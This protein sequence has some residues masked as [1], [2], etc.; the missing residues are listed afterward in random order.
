MNY[1]RRRIIEVKVKDGRTAP[2]L[3]GEIDFYTFWNYLYS[4][5]FVSFGCLL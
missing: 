1:C 3:A 5:L 2:G 4:V